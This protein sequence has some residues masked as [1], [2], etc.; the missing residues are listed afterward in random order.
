[1]NPSIRVTD[2]DARVPALSRRAVLAGSPAVVLGGSQAPAPAVP[3]R[4][5]DAY[6]VRPFRRW[7]ELNRRIERLQARWS[8]LET[9]LIHEHGWF[10][11]SPAEQAALPAARELKDIDG[12]LDVLCEQR[13]ALLQVLPPDGARTVEAVIAKLEV[14]EVL[15]GPDDDRS[16]HTL[17]AGARQDLIAISGAGLQ[18][19]DAKRLA[20]RTV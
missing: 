13:A 6:T 11:L 17:I 18:S 12:M 4:T 1:M 14:V 10:R 9:W 5:G 3:P 2:A 16:A 8:K 20:S 19:G 7:L 15:I